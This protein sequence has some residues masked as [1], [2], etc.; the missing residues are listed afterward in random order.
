MRR[1]QLGKEQDGIVPGWGY[2]MSKDPEVRSW[3]CFRSEMI[4]H[5]NGEDMEDDRKGVIKDVQ[6]SSMSNYWVHSGA[7]CW[8]RNIRV[9]RVG[10]GRE[11]MSLVCQV[12][13]SEK[14]KCCSQSPLWFL[15][16]CK[17][18]SKFCLGLQSRQIVDPNL[19]P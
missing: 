7:I 13:E 6:V 11:I 15:S 14:T 17:I 5:G 8:N 10:V 4:E 19:P 18:F 12:W 16:S 9:G 3:V 1:R 2:A